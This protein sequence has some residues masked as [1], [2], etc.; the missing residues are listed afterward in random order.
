MNTIGILASLKNLLLVMG[1]VGVWVGVL[2]YMAR[3]FWE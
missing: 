1:V 3:R 2:V